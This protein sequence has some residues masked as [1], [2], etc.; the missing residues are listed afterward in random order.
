MA[1]KRQVAGRILWGLATLG[2]VVLLSF[3]SS[4][5][6]EAPFQKVK[7]EIK[8]PEDQVFITEDEVRQVIDNEIDTSIIRTLG[9]INI[10]MLEETLD[11]QN[12]IQKSEVFSTVDGTLCINVLQKEAMARVFEGN[13]SYYLDT[14]GSP[15][16]LSP[17]FSA[18][19]PYIWGIPATTDTLSML[20]MIT[21]IRDSEFLSS[22]ISGVDYQSDK[23]FVL[24]P[25]EGH[26]TIFFGDTSDS[27]VKSQ[28]LEVFYQYAQKG[29]ENVKSI[30]LRF[31]G[32]VVTKKWNNHG[33]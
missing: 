24:Y 18:P 19:V 9:E 23:G 15:M 13:T 29:L 22:W 2:V 21:Q 28:K 27:K 10:S 20:Y 8:T 11:N 16:D 1:S 17:H 32:Q 7:I 33:N 26:H 14:Y 25:K 5:S 4:K 3:V 31:E 6:E 30:D 12:F